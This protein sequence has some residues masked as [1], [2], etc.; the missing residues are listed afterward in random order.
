MDQTDINSV[1]LQQFGFEI[2]VWPIEK[3]RGRRNNPKRH[4]HKDL[5]AIHE[6]FSATGFKDF[7]KYDPVADEIIDGNGRVAQALADGYK[8][9]PVL[10]VRDL[11]PEKIKLL[12]LAYNR[13]P[14]L[15]SYDEELLIENLAELKNLDVDFDFLHFDRFVNDI[16]MALSRDLDLVE[17]FEERKQEAAAQQSSVFAQ[18]SGGD[19][20]G[21]S[22]ATPSS[23]DSAQPA[24]VPTVP[25]QPPTLSSA[26]KKETGMGLADVV[27]PGEPEFGIPMLS[28]DYMATEVS[29]PCVKWGEISA[30]N[31]MTGTWHFYVYDGK[32]Y[33]L[34][35]NPEQLLASNAQN[36]VEINYSIRNAHSRAY[37]LGQIWRKRQT[38]RWLQSKGRRIIVDMNV[39]RKH[40]KDNLLGVP[41]GWKAFATRGY[42]NK[43]DYINDQINA[44]IE[45][46]GTEDFLF[47][48]YGGGEAIEEC[49][50]AAGCV[51]IPE[52]MQAIVKGGDGLPPKVAYDDYKNIKKSNRR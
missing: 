1:L 41:E 45:I 11:T 3:F 6:S 25:I 39:G 38:A 13:I 19:D 17:D 34:E 47:M 29:L 24:R 26:A 35:F 52:R 27:F 33:R 36:F 23:I 48:V 5:S 46:A 40:M 16:D 20:D 42:T 31:Q 22:A 18:S 49:C 30:K 50:K 21:D 15:A 10:I 37:A 9:L 8:S 4:R 14:E 7:V 2:D 44:A 32:L 43:V 51:Y 12:A 28:L